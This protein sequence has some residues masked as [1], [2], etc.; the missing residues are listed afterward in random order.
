MN[1]RQFLSSTSGLLVGALG[2]LYHSAYAVN[3]KSEAS[4]TILTVVGDIRRVNRSKSDMVKD[5]LMHKQGVHF[6][7]AYTFSLNDLEKL[8]AVSIR[9]TVEYDARV[10]KFTGPRLIDVLSVAGVDE[11][12]HTQLILRGIDGYSPEVNFAR[13]KE[14][15]YILATRMDDEILAIGGFGPL[16]A[17]YDADRINEFANK[18]LPQRFEACPWGLYCIEVVA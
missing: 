15:N 8:P 4:Q 10:H 6:D 13:A 11:S 5:Q 16:F 1:K 18:P 3:K 14:H 7:R 2:G 12:P 17:I 9:P